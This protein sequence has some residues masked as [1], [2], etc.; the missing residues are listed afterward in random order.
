VDD[1]DLVSVEVNIPFTPTPPRT[2]PEI[3]V[4]DQ[5]VLQND[6]KETQQDD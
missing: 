2:I 6:N 5:G 1:D 4:D 3:L